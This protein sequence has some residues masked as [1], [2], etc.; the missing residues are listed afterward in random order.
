MNVA[1]VKSPKNCTKPGLVL[2]TQAKSGISIRSHAPTTTEHFIREELVILL[3]LSAC[4]LST[5]NEFRFFS[6]TPQYR[7]SYDLENS[8]VDCQLKLIR[9]VD[10]F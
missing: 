7:L 1:P 8:N 3:H 2:W 4:L 5:R 10:C 9:T 6:S